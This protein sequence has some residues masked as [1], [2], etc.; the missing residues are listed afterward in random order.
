MKILCQLAAVLFLVQCALLAGCGSN[1]GQSV[2]VSTLAASQ[3]CISCHSGGDPLAPSVLPGTGTL[4]TS[5]WLSAA[6]NTQSLANKTGRGAGCPDCHGPAHNH[7]SDYC[8]QCHGGAGSP[9]ATFLNPDETGQCWNCHSADLA[10]T[11]PAHF[12]NITGAGFHPA[13]Y[14]TPNRQKACTSCHYPHKPDP[15]QQMTDWAKS[16]HGNVAEVAWATEDFKNA[17]SGGTYPCIR[18][19]T[20]TGYKNFLAGNWSDPFPAATWATAADGNGREVLTCD[21]CHASFNFRNSVRRPPPFTAPYNGGNSPTSFPDVGASNLCI[22]CHSGRENMDTLKAVANFTNVGFKN[23]HYL[24][25]A[26][27]MYMKTGFTEFVPP[28]TV[29]GTSTYGKTLTPDNVSTPGGIAGG[30]TSTHRKLGT[31]L[32]HGDSHNPSVFTAGN[33]DA[34]GPCVTCHMNAAGQ[35]DRLTSHSWAI[36]GN[37]YN[38]V[39]INC[40]TA[41]GATALTADNFRTV[42]LEEQSAVFQDALTLALTLLQNNQHISFNPDTYPYFYDDNLPLVNGK[43]QAVKDWTRG[44]GDQ[45]IGLKV[46]GAC[47][48][49]NLLKR[50]PA[51]FAHARTYSRRLLYDTIDFLDDGVINLSAGTTAVATDPT[52]Y[53]KGAQAYTDG[54]LTTLSPGTT[55]AMT[56]LIGWSRSTGAWNAIERP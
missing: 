25:A 51:A 36:D 44:T 21:A 53:G 48:N 5:D 20:A 1:D 52:T 6:H 19:H 11:S 14:A 49:I 16:D 39:C 54:T 29:I 26:G 27:L 30:V 56:Y 47:F 55:P 24:A 18:C 38:Q 46:M 3:K 17:K 31:P 43:K 13:M 12:Y 40:H 41:E 45:Q 8:G 35:P 23:P 33:F 50:E 22:A 10:K 4:I 2:P 37:A 34:D 7:P 28:D 32:I 15:T 42:F 9:T